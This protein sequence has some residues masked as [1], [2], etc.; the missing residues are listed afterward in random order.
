MFNRYVEIKTKKSEGFTCFYS[1]T[2]TTVFVIEHL[3][4]ADVQRL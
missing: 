4:K 2:F 1:T 3:K